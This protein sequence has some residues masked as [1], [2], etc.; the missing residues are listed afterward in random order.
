ME[1]DLNTA[2]KEQ[3]EISLLSSI[4]ELLYWDRMTHMPP[5]AVPGRSEQIK[6]IDSLIHERMTSKTLL[7]SVKRL[8][9]RDLKPKDLIVIRELDKEINKRIKVPRKHMQEL[10]DATISAEKRWREAK[11]KND[12]NVLKP[13]LKKVI[14]LKITQARYLDA[15]K[16][17]YDVLLD[18]YEEG[19]T[20]RKLDKIFTYL[21]KELFILLEKIKSSERYKLQKKINFYASKTVQKE[22]IGRM[23]KKL[24][25]REERVALD[26]SLHPFSIL[27]SSNDVRITTRYQN[28]ME[29]FFAGLHEAGHALYDLG[30]PDK[31]YR[32]AVYNASSFGMHESQAIFWENMIGKDEHFWKGFYKYYKKKM[33]LKATWQQFYQYVN[34]CRP[35][36]IRI[37]ADE[38]TYCFHIIIRYEI[39]KELI[40]GTLKIKDAKKIWDEKYNDHLGI[41]P[42]DDNEGILQDIHWA[43]GDFGYFPTYAIGMIYAAQ[44]FEK[45][46]K[47]KKNLHALIE[48]QD[49]SQI[50]GW[51][52]EKVHKKGKT[53]PSEDI[54]RQVCGEGLNP[55]TFIRY[56]N[57]KYSKIYGF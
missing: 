30:L 53:M 52:K 37:N 35:S 3:K 36:L 21:K 5:E 23:M 50:S 11:K 32:T 14:E 46:S 39:E 12:F 6:L 44:L 25:I 54:I 41:K 1:D 57:E 47:T 31:F 40:R 29:S 48:S 4:E 43:D 18:L 34:Q 16:D 33:C 56:L 2:Y 27:I 19:M 17:P 55:E 26:T 9:K 42:K 15:R 45:L 38:V 51:L 8:K 24:G 22:I 10:R 13:E 20:T 49:L 7:E 28:P